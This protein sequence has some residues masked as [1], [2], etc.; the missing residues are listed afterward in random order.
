MTVFTLVRLT[1]VELWRQKT[2]WGFLAVALL[3]LI[4]AILPTGAIEVNGQAAFGEALRGGLVQFAQF[5]S[6]FLAAALTST[7]LPGDMDRGTILLLVTKPVRRYQIILGKGLA[8]AVWMLGA[9]ALWGV[10]AALSISTRFGTAEFVPT[11]AAFLASSLASWLVIAFCLFASCLLPASA[12]LVATVLAWILSTAARQLESVA[13]NMGAPGYARVLEALS[14]VLPVG[15]VTEQAERL[16][17]GEASGQSLLLALGLMALWVVIAA[18]LF[19]RRDLS[20][21]G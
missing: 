15:W 8:A 13:A 18:V 9:W 11:L 16:A 5:V 10:I 14:W 4:P 7:L 6:F 3:M 2:P 12:A 19:S 20:S 1:L 17:A 21:G